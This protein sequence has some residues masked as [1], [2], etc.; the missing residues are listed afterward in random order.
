[1]QK[2]TTEQLQ[3]LRAD[4]QAKELVITE[5]PANP[6]RLFDHWM[7]EALSSDLLE[8]NAMTLSTCGEDGWPEG[9]VVLLK[10]VD[11]KGFKFYTNY[12]SAKGKALAQNPKAG[13]NFLWLELQR[14]VR[15]RGEVVKLSEAESTEYFQSRP[16]GSQL[17]AWTSPQSELIENRQFL[18]D[19]LLTISKQFEGQDPLPKPPNWGGYLLQPV[20]IEFWQGRQS[21]LHDRIQYYLENGSWGVRRLAP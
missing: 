2:V 12:E 19:R 21:R 16:R 5:V 1:M 8:P 13:I 20:A 15:I 18:E 3:K 10:G 7:S 17:G 6:F 9:R 14:Q 4:Y 11:Q